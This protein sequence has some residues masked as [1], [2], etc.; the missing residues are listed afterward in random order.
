MLKD[1]EVQ[2]KMINTVFFLKK[3]LLHI[4]YKKMLLYKVYY[5]IT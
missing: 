3:F 5:S 4:L 1:Q 2:V